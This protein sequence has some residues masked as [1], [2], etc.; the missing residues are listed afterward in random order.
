MKKKIPFTRDGLMQI[1]VEYELL[2]KSRP[3][4]VNDLRLAREKGDL[5]ENTAYRAARS[6]LSSIDNRL[7][8]LKRLLD[9]AYVVENKN[10]DFID[11]GT[12]VTIVDDNNISQSFQVV[13]THEA[14]IN[15]GKISSYSPLG[16]SLIGKRTN[17]KVTII[18]PSGVKT[19]MIKNISL[20]R[21]IKS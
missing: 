9:N 6:K 17:D 12:F 13:S 5:S 8:R 10:A 7:R 18:T 3:D 21:T 15:R 20:E 2:E 14:D 11:I 4:A 16:K 19:Y 1:Q